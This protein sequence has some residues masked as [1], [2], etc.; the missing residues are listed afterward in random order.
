[1]QIPAKVPQ[2]LGISAKK[3]QIKAWKKQRSRDIRIVVLFP[4]IVSAERFSE[5]E[6]L[7]FDTGLNSKS[8]RKV[9]ALSIQDAAKMS[10]NRIMFEREYAFG[11]NPILMEPFHTS[12]TS[13]Y[14]VNWNG[15]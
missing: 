6:A 11:E 3:G 12:K 5:I 4:N 10:P 1:M 7:K 14:F 2:K 15:K 9:S 8:I 13:T